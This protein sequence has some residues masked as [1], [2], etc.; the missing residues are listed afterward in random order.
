MSCL[1]AA[2][3]AEYQSRID[4]LSTTLAILE[5]TYDKAAARDIES[6]KFDS[7]EGS[8]QA[9]S[10]DLEKLDNQIRSVQSRLDYYQQ[11]ID[12]KGLYSNRFR[13]KSGAATG[14]TNVLG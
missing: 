8:Q 5:D 1:S 2:R 4:R 6:Y 7:G 11:K 14:G 9:K 12:G 13:R 10:R 3:K